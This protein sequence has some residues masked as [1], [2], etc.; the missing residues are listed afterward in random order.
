MPKHDKEIHDIEEFVNPANWRWKRWMV[1]ADGKV[2]WQYNQDYELWVDWDAAMKKRAQNYE[3]KKKYR[4]ANRDKRRQYYWDNREWHK[5]YM[6][7]WYQAN[8]SRLRPK[9]AKY[10][11]DRRKSDPLFALEARLRARTSAAISSSGYTKRARIK[12]ILGAEWG[13]VRSHLEGQF[14]DGMTWENRSEWHIDHIK[15]LA[16]A[17]TER[18]LISLC[19]YTNLQPLWAVDNLRKG[20]R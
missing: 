10:I 7:R 15:P 13:E 18:E 6:Q 14:A 9:R 17:K 1:R 5:S 3:A 8:K 4:E 11:R 12:E 20:A 16:S 19:H 2:F